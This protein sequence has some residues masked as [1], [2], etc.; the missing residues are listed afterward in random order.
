MFGGTDDTNDLNDF[1]VYDMTKNEWTL[2][3]SQNGPSPRSGSKMV[4]DPFGNQLF[5]IGRKSLRGN[6][7]LK[8]SGKS[9]LA[10]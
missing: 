4:F 3:E 1:W 7:N 6:D 8:V 10:T 2:I 9:V 5:L